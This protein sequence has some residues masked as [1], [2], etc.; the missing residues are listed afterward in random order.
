[1]CTNSSYNKQLKK[2]CHE[3]TS[4]QHSGT[5]KS[6][7]DSPCIRFYVTVVNLESS[8]LMDLESPWKP[9]TG[10]IYEG[11]FNVN[12]GTPSPGY[13]D[14]MIRRK[15]AEHKDSLFPHHAVRDVVPV[16]VTTGSN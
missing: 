13:L 15:Q 5:H 11:V 6:A 12:V 14:W 9:S 10:N 1:M 8:T 7:V 2:S 3:N 16:S 4:Q